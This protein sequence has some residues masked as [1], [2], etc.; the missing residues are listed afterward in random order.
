MILIVFFSFI[1]TQDCSWWQTYVENIPENINIE[2]NDDNCFGTDDL[3]NIQQIIN[4]NESLEGFSPLEV[5]SQTWENHRIIYLNLYGSGLDTIPETISEMTELEYLSLSANPLRFI[6]ETINELDRLERFYIHTCQLQ[7]IPESIGDLSNLRSIWIYN[8]QITSLPESFG[9]LEELEILKIGNN[10]LESFPNSFGN[11]QNLEELD[12]INNNLELLSENFDN[13]I[14]LN[15]INLFNNNLGEFINNIS[16]FESLEVLNLGNNSLDSISNEICSIYTNLNYLSLENN[17]LCPPYPDCLSEIDI[18]S[19]NLDSCN[20][21]DEGYLFIDSTPENVHILNESNCFFESDLEVLS[22]VVQFN[23]L[24]TVFPFFG[25]NQIWNSGRLISLNLSYNFLTGVPN[26]IQNLEFLKN[27]DLSN[28]QIFFLND[29]VTNVQNLEE[30]NLTNNPLI[31]LPSS[32]GNL[33]NLEKISISSANLDSIPESFGEL[34]SLNFIFINSTEIRTIPSGIVTNQNLIELNLVGNEIESLPEDLCDLP[35]S[36]FI[37]VSNNNLCNDFF[38]ECIDSWGIQNCLFND[39]EIISDNYRINK[40]YPNPFNSN[41]NFEVSIPSLHNRSYKLE[42]L[43]LNGV[44]IQEIEIP[45]KAGTQLISWQAK[46]YS[47][48]IYFAKLDLEN[49]SKSKKLI[50]IR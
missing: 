20:L 4:S 36:T 18:G 22:N 11:L 48:G 26:E 15:Y 13:L 17:N 23:N 35:V 46:K 2:E 5:G 16:D 42:I 9:N 44:L 47:S 41:V 25:F 14:N 12:A 43:S 3:E 31:E 29:A 8:N 50:L 32:I 10:N 45:N 49:I 30:L 6:P 34:D 33:I 37:D 1:F 7:E 24:Q 39:E 27:L 40:I 38:Y 28:N 21:C 19:Q